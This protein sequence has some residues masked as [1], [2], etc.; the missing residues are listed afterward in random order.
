M[1]YCYLAHHGVTGM[2]WGVM[3]GP[4]YPLVRTVSGQLD[5]YEQTKRKQQAMTSDY[6]IKMQKKKRARDDERAQK[7][8]LHE[9][10]RKKK[11]LQKEAAVNT[12]KQIIEKQLEAATDEKEALKQ[13]LREHPT[14]IKMH[15]EAFSD[16]E[17]N[18]L[19][20][21]IERDQVIRKISDD[22]VDHTLRDIQK[23]AN[24]VKNISLVVSSSTTIVKTLS[25][26]WSLLAVAGNDGHTR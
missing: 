23:A 11:R 13:Y 4:P 15:A 2:K 26:L 3:H 21:R 16:D 12:R 19:V 9:Q 1:E 10:I 24:A 7:K 6:A 14:A 20:H 8:V 22:E 18:E 5:G 25:Q 17:L